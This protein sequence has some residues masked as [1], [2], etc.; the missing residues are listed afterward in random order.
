M[1]MKNPN[2]TIG[3]RTRD[4]PACSAVPQP[5]ASPRAPT[6]N[7]RNNSNKKK[8]GRDTGTQTVTNGDNT[9]HDW[10]SLKLVLFTSDPRTFHNI[11][12]YN[13]TCCLSS[14]HFLNFSC[15]SS[16]WLFRPFQS[17]HERSSTLVLWRS[18]GMHTIHKTVIRTSQSTQCSCIRKTDKRILCRGGKC[19]FWERHA[20]YD[21]WFELNSKFLTTRL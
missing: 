12:P 17:I 16:E 6:D 5:T 21:A 20:T 15:Q 1:P 8:Q 3:N 14:V 2:D 10:T 13:V 19:L 4:L 9:D 18:Q 7:S 11:H